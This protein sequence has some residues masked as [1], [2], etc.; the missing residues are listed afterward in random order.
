MKTPKLIIFFLYIFISLI[1]PV[2][3][4][5]EFY[6]LSKYFPLEVGYKW[7][8]QIWLERKDVPFEDTGTIVS[9]VKSKERLEGL[10]LYQ[11]ESAQYD[12]PMTYYNLN[13]EG[14]WVHKIIYN[15]RYYI[16]SPPMRVLPK[17][18]QLGQDHNA[19]VLMEGFNFEDRKISEAAD[20]EVKLESKIEG[21]EDVT[22]PA[23]KFNDCIKIS[24]LVVTK[25]SEGITIRKQISW[26]AK[27]VG[28]VKGKETTTISADKVYEYEVEME[29][30]EGIIKEK[31]IGN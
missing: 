10:E 30:K 26:L 2:S 15:S 3:K 14:I 5:E 17:Y 25:S 1:T 31:K 4:A 28:K 27:D 20:C 11:V 13:E 22:V 23:G 6:D 16:F 9:S 19:S 18:V 24:S 29:L 12:I 8:Y 21:L 7:I